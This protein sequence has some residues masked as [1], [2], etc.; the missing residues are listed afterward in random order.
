MCSLH[1]G[2]RATVPFVDRKHQEKG[3]HVNIQRSFYTCKNLVSEGPSV[4]SPHLSSRS[5]V[6]MILLLK[7]WN[8]AWP[9][10]SAALRKNIMLLQ[11][12]FHLRTGSDLRYYSLRHLWQSLCFFIFFF[13][14]YPRASA[15]LSGACTDDSEN[16]ESH[17]TRSMFTLLKTFNSPLTSTYNHRN[18]RP[19]WM[20]AWVKSL[21][22][23]SDRNISIFV[24]F[25]F[26]YLL[27][28]E[29][30]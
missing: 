11:R 30:L 24:W 12:A 13:Y 16:M 6:W 22:L 3:V 25:F 1:R 21:K 4:R 23:V 15:R 20:G 27:L 8:H 17:A 28:L 26:L 18:T 9:V 5:D 10:R 29:P 14:F 19:G 2:C 7:N